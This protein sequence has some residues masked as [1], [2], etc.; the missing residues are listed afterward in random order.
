M[1]VVP[2]IARTLP[3]GPITRPD[4]GIPVVARLRWASGDDTDVPAIA[5]AWTRDAV[6][7][8]WDYTGAP[9]TDWIAAGDVRR[10]TTEPA[11]DPNRPPS[12]RDLKKGRR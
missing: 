3:R 11:K 9:R 6:E 2:R 1:P 8:H 10:T 4:A 5:L 12:S 7:I